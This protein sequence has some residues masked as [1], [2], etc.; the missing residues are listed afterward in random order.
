MDWNLGE[1][2]Q[3]VAD[4]ARRI[5]EDQATNE[6]LKAHEASGSPY[7][8]EL[9]RTLSDASILGTAIPETHGGSGLGFMGLCALL[10]EVGRAVA[11]VPIFP[12][13]ALG[14]LPIAAFG[15]PAQKEEW[16]P[17]AARGE[18]VLTAAL[19][20]AES[21]DPRSPTTR[22]ALHADGA[23][24]TGGKTNVPAAEQAERILIPARIEDGSTGL[25]LVD[26]NSE[27]VSL[28][29]QTTSDR[30]PHARIALDGARVPAD[31]RLGDGTT[32]AWLVERA[33][34]ARCILQLGVTERALE[35]TAQ[36]ARDRIQFDRPIGSFQ[37]VHQRA[38]DAYIHV[39][40]LRLTALEAAWRL[41]RDLPVEEHVPVAKYWAAEGGQFAAY[42][43]QH[44]HGGVG[45][46][47]DYPLHR[48]FMWAIQNEHDL[49]SARHQLERIGQ[50]IAALGLPES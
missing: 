26:P 9:W 25:F 38:G 3:A 16:L 45:V 12:S 24:L 41:A 6:R 30:Q 15:N 21:T 49:G 29:T 32:L 2:E 8:E 39:E 5:L 17:R 1:E 35:M 37:A 7:D 20:E 27:G 13:L 4:L 19:T 43:C 36:Y 18:I 31:A 28:E 22:A 14:A 10:Q 47:V 11:P 40:A 34:V 42:A 50:R 23:V 44:L 48:Y 33:T 46:D